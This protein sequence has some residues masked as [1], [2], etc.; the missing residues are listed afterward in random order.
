[1]N[2]NKHD[3]V[4]AA[5]RILGLFCIARAILN[6]PELGLAMW[7]N[8]AEATAMGLAAIALQLLVGG[9]LFLRAPAIESWTATMDA[10]AKLRTER[11]EAEA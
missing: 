3:L 7:F 6:L 8:S 9:L 1:M 5:V 2:L 10:N 4:F 11:K